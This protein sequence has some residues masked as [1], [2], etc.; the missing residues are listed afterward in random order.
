MLASIC[1]VMFLFSA[2]PYNIILCRLLNFVH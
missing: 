1:Y 2:F